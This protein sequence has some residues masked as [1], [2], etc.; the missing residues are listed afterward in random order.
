MDEALCQVLLANSVRISI[1]NITAAIQNQIPGDSHV[2][3]FLLSSVDS[4]VKVKRLCDM[5]WER[6]SA[7]IFSKP[8]QHLCAGTTF[9][10]TT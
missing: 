7:I 3:N 2:G 10:R 5:N 1:D 4:D 9:L 6:S 8:L